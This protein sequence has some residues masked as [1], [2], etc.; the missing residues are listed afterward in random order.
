MTSHLNVVE[1]KSVNAKMSEF[2]LSTTL[3]VVVVLGSVF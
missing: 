3:G 1:V 2:G